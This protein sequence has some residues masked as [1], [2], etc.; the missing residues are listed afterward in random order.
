MTGPIEHQPAPPTPSPRRRLAI[1]AEPL[2]AE[3]TDFRIWAPAASEV[4][5]IA[6]PGDGSVLTMLGAEGNGYFS[7]V[8]N[9]P[10]GGR[11]RYRLDNGEALYPDPASRY[12]PDGPH[13][14]SVVVDPAAFTWTDASWAGITRTGQVVYELHPGTFTSAGN[15]PAAAGELDELASLGITVIELMPVAEFEGRYGWGYDGVDL[16]APSH[17]YG[18]P[19]QLRQFIDRAHHAG[20]GVILDVVYN[21]MG[22]VGN[23][24]RAFSPSYFTDRYENE[25]GDAIN[26]DG[27][28]AGPVREFFLANARYW[29]EEFHFDGLRLDATQQ[30]FDASPD[31]L[32][33]ELAL[34]ARRAAAPRSI[35]IVAENE[36]QHPRLVKPPDQGGFGLDAL[37]N[38][39]FHHSAMVALTGQAEAYYSDTCGSA[40]E[41]IAAAK[42]G[43]LFQGQHYSWQGKPRGLPGLDLDPACFVNY[44]QNHDQVANSAHGLRGHQLTSPARWRAMTAVLLLL[45][46]TPMLF[47]GQEFSSSAP[48]L[49][50]VDFD[51]ELSAAVRKGRAEFLSQFPSVLDYITVAPLTD[52]GSP[53]T[54]E[55][56]KLDFAERTT[57][58]AAYALHR[59][60]LALRRRNQALHRQ[61]R[62]VADGTVLAPR[63]LAL[64]FFAS[65]PQ[66]DRLLVVNLGGHLERKSVADP[67][68]A[69]PEGCEWALEWSSEHPNY[70]GGG[71]PDIWATRGWTVPGEI[72]LVFAPQAETAAAFGK[73]GE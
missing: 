56:C 26:F 32:L 63:A 68:V 19:D 17:L 24:L 48:F 51:A 5:L 33:K 42:Y 72:A 54:F 44:L 73:S 59:D 43:Y 39:D 30:I 13:G 6:G 14:P 53:A 69:P 28:D 61:D 55:R 12:Q 58:A 71:S 31:H 60:L 34:V 16:F 37:W 8:A 62:R 40:Q 45:P 2:D 35:Y 1:G 27:P 67:L 4:A 70:G 41:I 10:A 36:T 57:H 22:P 66:D 3:R 65:D 46:G 21:H 25:W 20:I 18:T 9:L 50:F 11:Y 52:P 49:F 7:G 15:W 64:R 38:D 23:Y 29:I 47:Q